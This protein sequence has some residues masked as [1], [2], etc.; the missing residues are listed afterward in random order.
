[1]TLR[2]CRYY[3]YLIMLPIFIS[4]NEHQSG[5]H[6]GDT[7]YL[8][9]PSFN[10]NS[11]HYYH[12]LIEKS[13]QAIGY[14][15]II[16]T[17]YKHIPQ[18]RTH[19]MLQHG[20]LSLMWYIESEERNKKYLPVPVGLT[21]KL[22]GKRILFIPEGK[23]FLYDSVQTID[24]FRA[25]KVV[26][27]FGKNWYDEE[28]WNANSLQCMIIDGEWR[29]IYRL[30]QLEKKGIDYFSRGLTEIIPESKQHPSLAI[31]EKLVFIYDRD[32]I[33]YLSP[34]AKSYQPILAKAIQN[35]KE[36]GL[37]DSLIQKYWG[38]T[39]TQLHYDK[40]VKL[41]LTLPQISD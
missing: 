31:E 40:R 23:Q 4:A 15:V 13:V 20:K 6:I 22:I 36:S 34:D 21:N 26:G 11:H 16:S 27:A 41:H 19:T 18:K 9:L 25:L 32:F 28:V 17:P 1:M 38:N 12:E 2:D 8:S 30:L 37:M 10:D 24:D 35:A 33:F 29:T 5:I 7:L 39:F 14:E 3:L